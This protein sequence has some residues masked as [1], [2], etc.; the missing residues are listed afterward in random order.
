MSVFGNIMSAIFGHNE[1]HAA[2]SQ[3]AP[4]QPGPATPAAPGAAASQP[5]PAA[6]PTAMAP[7][8]GPAAA[9]PAAATTPGQ[10]NVDV[11]A[12]L[13]KLQKASREKLDWRKSI[14]DLMKLLK[15]DSSMKARQELAGELNYP[16]DKKDSAAMN[17]WLHKQVIKK[18]AENGG[19]VPA[20]LLD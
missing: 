16:G 8:A 18:F 5:S 9:T 12:V 4:G 14:V 13:D 17:I 6:K 1:A 3:P 20:D 7:A 19:K 10:A 2:E 15:L 11:A